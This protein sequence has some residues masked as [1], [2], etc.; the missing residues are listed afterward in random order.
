MISK[1]L[2]QQIS[3][4]A[5]VTKQVCFTAAARTLRDCRI[6]AIMRVEIQS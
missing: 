3:Q 4:I 5:V 1:R 2:S 6:F